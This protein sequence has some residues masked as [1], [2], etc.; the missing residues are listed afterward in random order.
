MKNILLLLIL[1]KGFAGYAQDGKLSEE[2]RKE[3]EAQKVA[4][5]TQQLDLTPEEAAAFW[6]LYNEMR[7]K[8]GDI[9][10]SI[11]K[12]V[13]ETKDDAKGLREEDYRK[14]VNELLVAEQNMINVKKD[15]YAR[16]MKILPASKV[17]KLDWTERKFHRQLFEKL[18]KEPPLSPK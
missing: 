13:I 6:P 1:C 4:F 15:Y 14:K 12:N 17:Y 9:E 16:I 3:F 10:V 8:I 5:F 18:K 7:K 11:R 2:K